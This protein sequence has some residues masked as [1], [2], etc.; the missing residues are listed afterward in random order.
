MDSEQFL[1]SSETAQPSERLDIAAAPGVLSEKGM[2]ESGA[3]RVE[4]KS[5]GQSSANPPTMVLPQVVVNNTTQAPI[6]NDV[7]TTTGNNPTAAKD[8]D[9]IE[10]EWV[11]RVKQVLKDTKDDPYLKEEEVKALKI[12]Y[13]DKR[14]N[15]KLGNEG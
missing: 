13:L 15:R 11:D 12:D 2:F 4:Q 9:S 1:T 5:E 8:S 7:K 10:K 14:Y 3:E 6:N